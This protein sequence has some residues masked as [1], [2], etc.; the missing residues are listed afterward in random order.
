M[1]VGSIHSN[2]SEQRVCL[3]A[4]ASASVVLWAAEVLTAQSV[5]SKKEDS[6]FVFIESFQGTSSTL[7][8]VTKLNSTTGFKFN[9]HFE[10]DAG[11]PVYFVRASSSSSAAGFSSGNGIGNVFLDLRFS[12]SNSRAS[13]I[14]SITGT[15]PTGDPAK[16]LST[17][18]ATVD[19][20]NYLAF[21]AGRITPFANVGLANSISDTR[22]FTRPFTSL[23]KVAH[24]EGGADVEVWRALSLGASAY[25]DAP[26]GQQKVFSKLIRRGQAGTTGQGK[27]RGPKSGVF[28]TQSLTVGGSSIARDNGGSV[29]LDL[30]PGAVV[31]FQAGLTRSAEYDLNS[32]F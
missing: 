8:T 6:G 2:F 20:N 7:G 11:I 16:G 26:F 9:R 32:F 21:T 17:G 1:R 19:W 3:I 14:S 12:F 15:A 22:F 5:N 25:A 28:E 13:F 4:V 10:I 29:W 30:S 23:G 18:R 31:D 27:G 24:F